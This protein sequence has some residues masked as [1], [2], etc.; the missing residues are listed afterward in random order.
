MIASR[1]RTVAIGLALL[2][3]TVAMSAAQRGRGG[4]PAAAARAGTI[5][6]V[7]V[8]DREVVVYLPPA[9]GGDGAR[10]FPVFY[11][12]ADRPIEN[13]G[14]P[15]AADRLARAQGFSEPIVVLLD[16]T[17]TTGDLD[18][19]VAED[20]LVY[21]DGQYRTIAARISR[22][23]AGYSAGGDSALRIAMKRA[24]VF[25]SLHL[26]N[27]SISEPTLTMLDGAAGDL[28]RYYAV[29]IDIGTKDT[30]I[31]SNRRLHD[32][33]TRLRIPHYYEEYEGE[34]AD[35]VS[36]RVAT[37]LLPFFSKN[38]TAPAN[39]TSPAVQ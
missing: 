27:A 6:R 12:L 18:K 28:R 2:T 25:S 16:A 8:H 32:A 21:I 10:R 34:H 7:T 31:A 1:T 33:M 20:L 19:F 3:S 30:L 36:E 37:R 15:D 17:S 26:M 4:A 5:E 22:G 38:L 39:P 29:A 24:N 13:L 11:L 35:K 14:L 9:Y 23:L